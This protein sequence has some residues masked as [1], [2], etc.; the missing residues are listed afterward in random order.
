MTCKK[1]SAFALNQCGWS[2]G[3]LSIIQA[4][5]SRRAVMWHFIFDRLP[6]DRDLCLAVLDGDAFHALEFPCRRTDDG[7]WVEAR[8]GRSIDVRPTHWREWFA[9]SD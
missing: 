3:V 6:K 1:A 2:A 5:F 8:T 7:R 9:E 4:C